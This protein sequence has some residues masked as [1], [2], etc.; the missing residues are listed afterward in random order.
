SRARRSRWRRSAGPTLTAPASGVSHL[1]AGTDAEAIRLARH[2]LS[3]LPL[4]NLEDP[5]RQAPRPPPESAAAELARIVP[6][7]PQQPYDVHAV[8]DRIAD[9]DS[10]LEIQPLWAT[11]IVVGFARFDGRPVGLVANNPA[12]LA[13]TLD[14]DASTKA[15][16]FVRF[17]DAF[18][19]PVL[20]LVDVPGFLPGTGQEHGGI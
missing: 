18:N 8:I 6:E 1:T 7:S 19:L 15:A 12:T 3:Y 4:N 11:N 9:L 20:T 10:F 16:R 17:L 2:L 14:I 5:P 13:G